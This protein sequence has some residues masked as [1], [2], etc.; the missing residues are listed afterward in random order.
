L[1]LAAA[2]T[3]KFGKREHRDRYITDALLT[4]GEVLSIGNLTSGAAAQAGAAGKSANRSDLGFGGF[5]NLKRSGL[6]YEK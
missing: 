5:H 3:G 6:D 4:A 1:A 2:G